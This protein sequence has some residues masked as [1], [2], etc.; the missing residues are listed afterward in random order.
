MFSNDRLKHSATNALD[1]SEFV[2]N[3]A[4]YRLSL[5]VKLTGEEIPQGESEFAHAGA[6]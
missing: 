1:T 5:A 4:T 6:T 3:F 2:A